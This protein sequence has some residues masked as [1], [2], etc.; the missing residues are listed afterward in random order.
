MK[1][2]DVDKIEI[3][4][5][6][7]QVKKLELIEIIGA[8]EEK[9]KIRY[10]A[11]LEKQL[12]IYAKNQK[13]MDNILEEIATIEEEISTIQFIPVLNLTEKYNRAACAFNFLQSGYHS[14]KEFKKL[15]ALLQKDGFTP[16]EYRDTQ[17]LK[18]TLELD[19]LE[20]VIKNKK[21]EQPAQE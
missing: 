3:L 9:I 8:P 19:V 18:F 10:P 6:Q 20:G 2:S 21:M 16:P 12:G 14:K 7:L 5:Q 1:K 17:M 11:D 4:H 13:A 15:S